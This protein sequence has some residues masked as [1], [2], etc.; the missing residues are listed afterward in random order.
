MRRLRVVALLCCMLSLTLIGCQASLRPETLEDRVLPHFI[1]ALGGIRTGNWQQASDSLRDAEQ[2]W[3]QVKPMLSLISTS[4]DT[5]NLEE[6]IAR[7]RA[8][9]EAQSLANSLEEVVQCIQDLD[10]IVNW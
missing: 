4:N 6:S 1:A 3:K 9:V 7:A 2:V 5:R 8:A 10:E